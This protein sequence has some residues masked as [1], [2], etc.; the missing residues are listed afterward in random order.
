[1]NNSHN[2]NHNNKCKDLDR[3]LQTLYKLIQAVL[4]Q[5]K[6]GFIKIHKTKFKGLFLQQICK[7]GVM[8]NI[9]QGI[10]P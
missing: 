10:C 6:F 3:L 4:I 9:L 2:N 1:M 8:I 5:I 7:Y